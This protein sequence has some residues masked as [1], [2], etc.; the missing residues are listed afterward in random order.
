[1]DVAVTLPQ[2]TSS[3][4]KSTPGIHLD[5]SMT[6]RALRSKLALYEYSHIIHRRRW[7]MSGIHW[8][9]VF[10]QKLSNS[11]RIGGCQRRLRIALTNDFG[12]SEATAEDMRNMLINKIL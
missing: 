12:A 10:S 1:M 11:L 8:K 9:Q 4:L 7:P 5:L 3:G 6:I 2:Y